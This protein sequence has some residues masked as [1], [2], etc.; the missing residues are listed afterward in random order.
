[1]SQTLAAVLLDTCA[2]IWIANGELVAPAAMSAVTEAALGGGV[3][4]SAI[5]AWEI[6]LLS[7]PRTA[8]RVGTYFMPDPKTWFAKFLSRTSIRLAALTPEIA[9]DASYLPGKFH[10]DPADRLIVATARHLGVPVIT[11]DGRI[12]DYAAAGHVSVVVC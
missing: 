7:R 11:R 3:F 9:V 4:V 6:G 12:A 2:V 8:G 10:R 5:S 1:M